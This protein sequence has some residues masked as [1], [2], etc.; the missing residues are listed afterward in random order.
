MDY[1]TLRP[2]DILK[3]LIVLILIVAIATVT[4]S[5]VEYVSDK[6]NW[7]DGHCGCGG[8]WVYEQ[9]V[10]HRNTTNYLYH[11]DKCGAMIELHTKK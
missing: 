7:N 10:G 4:I 3:A 5:G 6:N 2:S 9:A 8:N 11:C 1:S